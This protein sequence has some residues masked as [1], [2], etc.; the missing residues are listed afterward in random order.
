MEMRLIKKVGLKVISIN[1]C[2]IFIITLMGCGAGNNDK[3]RKTEFLDRQFLTKTVYNAT[4]SSLEDRE[5]IEEELEIETPR[6]DKYSILSYDKIKVEKGYSFDVTLDFNLEPFFENDYKGQEIEVIISL[7]KLHSTIEDGWYEQQ[8][9][10]FKTDSEI[11]GFLRPGLGL[12]PDLGNLQFG[13]YMFLTQNEMVKY[14]EK[15]DLCY[16]ITVDLSDPKHITL[17]TERSQASVKGPEPV[18]ATVHSETFTEISASEVLN[19]MELVK[20]EK[21][22]VDVKITGFVKAN[23][24]VLVTSE[25]NDAIESIDFDANKIL[26]LSDEELNF[27]ELKIGD[28]IQVDI[29]GE[30][31]E[32]TITGLEY[33]DLI[34][35]TS[36]DISSLQ[37]IELFGLGRILDAENKVLHYNDLKVNDVITVYYYKRF[38]SYEPVNIRVEEIL[39]DK[40]VEN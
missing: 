1:L 5:L 36:N 34:Q 18:T 10:I 39:V 9:I 2:F 32:F 7:F 25:D 30:I 11:A 23:K 22:I 17:K 16:D 3:N 13:S 29:D 33:R 19:L 15:D 26:N 8:M 28:Q 12:E 40:I 14:Y 37:T 31:E 6:D 4:V 21:E 27:D 24:K 35:V 20:I 38:K